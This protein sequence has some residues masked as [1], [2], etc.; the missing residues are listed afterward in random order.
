M[1]EIHTHVGLVVGIVE[2]IDPTVFIG[3][4]IHDACVQEIPFATQLTGNG[5][6]DDP[7]LLIDIGGILGNHHHFVRIDLHVRIPVTVFRIELV[8]AKSGRG[9]VVPLIFIDHLFG[10]Q[11][12]FARNRIGIIDTLDGTKFILVGP[13]PRDR[14]VPVQMGSH[15]FAIFVFR[16]LE[17]VIA[18]ISRVG[19]TLTDN[20]VAHPIDELTIF[21][22][23]HLRLIHPKGI[24]RNAFGLRHDAPQRI[25]IGRTHLKSPSFDQNHPIGSRFI[26]RNSS[27]SCHLP[28]GI[29]QG[30]T[31]RGQQGNDHQC[32]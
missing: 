23:R 5:L 1:I 12:L 27:C 6:V 2:V 19:Q 9:I 17:E 4:D 26:K 13:F 29:P 18:A 28:S 11:F 3:I 32:Y 7:S 14:T 31:A 30:F 15:R 21:G 25:L 10:I 24:K 20:G 16:N 8:F 22:I